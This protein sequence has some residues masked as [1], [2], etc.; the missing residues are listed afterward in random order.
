MGSADHK[1]QSV[2][3]LSCKSKKPQFK[4]KQMS[5]FFPDKGLICLMF[6]PFYRFGHP[7]LWQNNIVASPVALTVSLNTAGLLLYLIWLL[8][9]HLQ[10]SYVVFSSP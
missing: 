7:G 5:L 6:S 9:Q 8:L 3:L 2:C 4:L 1:G 10:A